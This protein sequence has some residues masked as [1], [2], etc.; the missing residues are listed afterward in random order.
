MAQEPINDARRTRK[1]CIIPAAGPNAGGEPGVFVDPYQP[2]LVVQGLCKSY[3]KEGVLRSVSFSLFP[4]NVLGVCG[5]NGAG[6]TTL[7][8]LLAS[9][10]TPDAGTITLFGVPAGRSR[11]Y[12]E[13]IGFVPQEIALS[14]R[15]TV[16][17]NLDFWASMRGLTG[18]SREAAVEEAISLSHIG[19]FLNKRVSRCSGDMARR[20]NL[21]AGFVGSPS[22]ILLDEATA[23]IDEDNRDAILLSVKSLQKAGRMVIMV[24]HYRP[25]LEAICGGIITL[26]DGQLVGNEEF[27]PQAP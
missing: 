27:A 10:L 15:L 5:S 17:Q 26:K 14:P 25:E 22:L 9:I 7:I 18:K 21:A 23:G 16:R 3:G 12:R 19:G 1:D 20:A 4:G 24:N 13:K 6:K 8:R 2:G 11:A